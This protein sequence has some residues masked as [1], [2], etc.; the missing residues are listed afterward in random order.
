MAEEKSVGHSH[1][2]CEGCRK[3]KDSY[4]EETRKALEECNKSWEEAEAA[5]QQAL[6]KEL[7][8]AKAKNKSLQ[9]TVAAFQIATTVGVTLLGQEA[10]DKIMEK[11]NS[12]KEVQT[13]ITETTG[14]PTEEKAETKGKTDGKKTVSFGSS[15]N[16]MSPSRFNQ[17][18]SQARYIPRI[19]VT[20]KQATESP[21]ELAS[22]I[23]VAHSAILDEQGI[24][25]PLLPPSAKQQVATSSIDWSQYI[26]TNTTP[27][28]EAVVTVLGGNDW[29]DDWA[30]GAATSMLISEPVP[31]PNTISVF[32]LSLINS[33]RRR[34]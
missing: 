30:G 32:A 14:K 16:I 3:L 13:K 7:E 11:V 12:V 28:I 8:E 15:D 20:D 33:P 6:E 18:M 25:L 29:I 10:F 2:S 19:I 22:A 24:G 9:K 4:C 17:A 26:V 21:V 23:T 27:P 1:A 34:A 31:A 5:S